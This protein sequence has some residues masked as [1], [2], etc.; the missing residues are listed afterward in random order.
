[1]YPDREF[2]AE[3][4]GVPMGN[5][6]R[7]VA[8]ARNAAILRAVRDVLTETLVVTTREAAIQRVEQSSREHDRFWRRL[9]AHWAWRIGTLFAALDVLAA[10][11]AWAVSPGPID[12][13]QVVAAGAAGLVVGNRAELHRSRLELSVLDDL[14]AYLLTAVLAALALS[15]AGGL[16]ADEVRLSTSFLFG[17]AYFVAQTVTRMIAYPAVRLLRR[18]RLVSHPVVLVGTGDIAQ[19]LAGAMLAHREYGLR[20]VGFVDT[21]GDRLPPEDAALLPVLGGLEALP[22]LL[23]QFEVHDVVFAFGGQPDRHMV[24]VVRACVRLDLQVFVVP[25]YFEL[26]GADR[27][28]RIEVLWGV[29]LV[30][31]RRWPLRP[32]RALLKRGLDVLLAGVGLVVASPLMLL[33]AVLAR[34]DNGPGVIFRQERVGRDGHTFTLLKFRSL[35]AKGAAADQVWSI[36]GDQ[37]V[38][39]I[40]RFLRRSSLDELPQLINVLRGDMSLVGPR[41][42]RP[43]F[44]GNFAERIRNYADRH[45]APTGLTGW[46][47]VNGLRGNGTSIED[48]VTFDNYYIDNWSLWSDVKIMVRTFAAV[49]RYGRRSPPGASSQA[50]ADLLSALATPPDTP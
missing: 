37:R 12:A 50:R 46:A 11:L 26:Y 8:S 16:T 40:G 15:A 47:Q 22:D 49:T 48:R 30:R 17:V 31:L 6:G 34:I 25:R 32:S 38:S 23:D 7:L 41:P 10:V 9:R 19:R 33:C 21:G 27:R 1:M 14:P 29:P 36:D 13:W 24:R 18:T 3:R 35:P 4:R 43:Y 45:R 42:E 28:A 39:R 44:V 5:R 20:P 2:S